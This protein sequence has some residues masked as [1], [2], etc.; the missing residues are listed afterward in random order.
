MGSLS[1][2]LCSQALSSSWAAQS[3]APLASAAVNASRAYATGSDYTIIDHE[4]DAV[5]VGAGGAW[6]CCG[7]ADQLVTSCNRPN[8]S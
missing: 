1:K 2:L 4:Y 3:A 7:D 6:C 5:V 8:M